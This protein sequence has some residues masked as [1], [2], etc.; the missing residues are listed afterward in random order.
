MRR[1]LARLLFAGC[2]C[3]ASGAGAQS[4]HIEAWSSIS[5]YNVYDVSRTTVRLTLPNGQALRFTCEPSSVTSGDRQIGLVVRVTTGAAAAA[6]PTYSI[7]VDVGYVPAGGHRVDVTLLF[8]NGSVALVQS[9]AIEIEARGT[10]CNANPLA[11]DLSLVL[12]AVG[13]APFLAGKGSDPAWLASHGNLRLVSSYVDG[14]GL[15]RIR[16]IFDPLADPFIVVDR[17][18]TDLDFRY[19]LYDA[20]QG[21]S[22]LCPGDVHADLIEFRATSREQY[23]Y[24]FDASELAALDSGAVGGWQRTGESFRVIRQAGSPRPIENRFHRVYRFWGGS[25]QAAPAHFFTLSQDE[26]AVLRDRPSW[27]WIFEG[28]PYW[29]QALE[30][31]TCAKGVPLRRLYNGGAGGAPAHRYTTRAAVATEMVDRGWIDEG[32]VMC[33]AGE[34]S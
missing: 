17:L 6:C 2:A 20:L 34:G 11:H 32:A 33:V 7:L 22:S 10:K 1:I 9:G 16:G 5:P 12:D 31:G 15:V 25:S 29:A 3:L 13:V 21:C 4:L 27:N 8:A 28:A 14:A 18:K 24:T 30:G 19:V 26:C 23:F